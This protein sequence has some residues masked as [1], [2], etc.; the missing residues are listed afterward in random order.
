[1]PMPVWDVIHAQPAHPASEEASHCLTSFAEEPA[2]QGRIVEYVAAE[3]PHCK[4][5]DKT[6]LE[7]QRQWAVEKHKENLVWEKKECWDTDWVKGKDFDDCERARVYSYPTV[8]F[9][10]GAESR[11]DAFTG[12]RTGQA[13]VRFANLHQRALGSGRGS[14]RYQT[15]NRD[16][17]MQGVCLR[18]LIFNNV[19]D[20]SLNGQERQAPQ[21]VQAPIPP[22]EA[23][24]PLALVLASAFL[25]AS[26]L[27]QNRRH[28]FTAFL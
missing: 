28:A 27:G 11:G 15:V 16:W 2:G 25:P 5:F 3:C 18:P 8:L 10:R 14:Q 23:A 17:T 22:I 19:T 4:R 7:A 13:L 12:P 21:A 24:T 1:M 9:H 26:G 6:W 20:E